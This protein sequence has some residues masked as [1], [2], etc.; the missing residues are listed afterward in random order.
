MR[1][2]EA[3]DAPAIAQLY[4][5]WVRVSTASWVAAE[6]APSG[7]EMLGRIVAA[8]GRRHPWLVAVADGAVVGYA[9]VAP[10][11]NAAGWQGCVENSVYVAPGWDR[12]GV[13]TALM[14]NLID[15]CSGHGDIAHL[16]ALISVDRAPGGTAALGAGSVAL[17]A[18]LGFREAGLLPR[19]GAKSGLLLDCLFMLLGACLRY[20]CDCPKRSYQSS[21]SATKSY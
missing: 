2:A 15:A 5:H 6:A 14:R 18:R 10:F 9:C 12:R 11:R 20:R 17:H 3:E 16:L 21:P 1:P 19:V 13:G 8:R 7:E 4:G